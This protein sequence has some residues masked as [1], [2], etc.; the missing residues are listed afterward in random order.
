MTLK[1]ALTLYHIHNHVAVILMTQIAASWLDDGDVLYE[2]ISCLPDLIN[3]SSD[4]QR[5]TSE[6]QRLDLTAVSLVTR[7]YDP[8]ASPG[9]L[10]RVTIHPGLAIASNYALETNMYM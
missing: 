6:K 3:G 4:P 10:F 9:S 5:R 2:K 8:K 7:Y 1:H